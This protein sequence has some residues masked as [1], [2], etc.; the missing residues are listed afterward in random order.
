MGFEL[1]FIS[2]TGVGGGG[3]EAVPTGLESLSYGNLDLAK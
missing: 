3:L 1:N 2:A